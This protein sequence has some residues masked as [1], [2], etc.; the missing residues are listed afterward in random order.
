MLGTTENLVL[1][2]PSPE[3]HVE[4]STNKCYILLY[5]ITSLRFLG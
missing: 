4:D 1:V 3:I 5:Y 2:D